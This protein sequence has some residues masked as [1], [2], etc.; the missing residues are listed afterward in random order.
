MIPTTHDDEIWLSNN[1]IG[2]VYCYAEEQAEKVGP[3]AVRPYV[4]YGFSD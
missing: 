1:S 4:N 2:A 3:W